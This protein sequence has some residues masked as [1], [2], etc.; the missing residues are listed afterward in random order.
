[1]AGFGFRRFRG[2]AYRATTYDTPVWVRPNRR[3]GR[4]SRPRDKVVAQ[5]CC[6]DPAAPYAEFVRSEDLQEEEAAEARIGLWQLRITEGA[7]L[8]ISSEEHADELG[9]DWAALTS[10]DWSYCQELT[11]RVLDQGGRGVIAPSAALPGSSSLVLFGPRSELVWGL[12]P[13]LSIQVPARELVSGAP[14]PG[15]I[16]ATRRHGDPFPTEVAPE[17]VE[18]LLDPIEG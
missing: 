3:P 9:L 17:P 8:D 12:H 2:T 15:L 4:W 16:R 18:H 6:L 5:Y 14:R 13:R 1:M 7:V 10:D 11:G